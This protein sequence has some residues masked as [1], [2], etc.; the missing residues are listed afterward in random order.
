[1]VI[2]STA[3]HLWEGNNRTSRSCCRMAPLWETTSTGYP[4]DNEG[5]ARHDTKVVCLAY[6]PVSEWAL[7]SQG[8]TTIKLERLFLGYYKYVAIVNRLVLHRVSV[9]EASTRASGNHSTE[10]RASGE[11]PSERHDDLNDQRLT[12]M[13]EATKPTTLVLLRC[14]ASREVSG[15]PYLPAVKSAAML[16]PRLTRQTPQLVCWARTFS[17][18]RYNRLRTTELLERGLENIKVNPDRLW[19]TIHSTAQWTEPR[20]TPA[21]DIRTAGLARL[22]LSDEDKQARDWFVETTK[23]LG[24]KTYVDQIGNI[25]SIRPGLK[26]GDVP[27]TF[28]GSH[29][30]SQPSGGRFDGVLGV[31]AGVE[32]LRVLN[33]NWIETEGPV[34]VVNWTNE[35]GAKYP[36]SMM[37]SGVWSGRIPLESAWNVKSVT[38]GPVTTVREELERI[39]YLGSITASYK[40]GIPLGAHFELHIEQGPKLDASKQ[41][42]GVVQGV[43]AYKWFTLTVTGREAHAGTTDLEHR[44]DALHTA[45]HFMLEVRSIAR[46]LNGLAT[47]GLLTVSPGS[48]NTIPGQVKMSLDVRH[49]S[50]EGLSEMVKRV[51]DL[52]RWYASHA[53]SRSDHPGPTVTMEEDFAS[54]AVLFNDEAIKCVEESAASVLGTGH[55]SLM[56]RMTSGAGHDSVCTN[57]H[58]PTAMIFIPSKDGISHNPS[59]WSEKDDCATGASVLLQ[60][61]LRMDKLRKDRGDFG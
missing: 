16:L 35:E 19:D 32:M 23:S 58:C 18:T 31:A 20:S 4:A 3:S 53:S 39:G 36:V 47:V 24:C 61:V 44:Q 59:E 45:A 38:P 33:D 51:Q 52:C 26:N 2:T 48:V 12:L 42:I 11:P 7:S 6:A 25:F 43:Q 30:D 28:V 21:D 17:S 56:Q 5:L 49:P 22:T 60:S 8:L 46:E 29:L 50:D 10:R 55:K 34:G 57:M 9:T 15:S 27:A 41:K 14:E 13:I 1:M 54:S 37:G 40:D